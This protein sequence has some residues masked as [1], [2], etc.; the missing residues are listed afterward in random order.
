MA[1]YGVITHMDSMTVSA[2]D[3]VILSHFIR[4]GHNI[5]TV[6]NS[7]RIRTQIRYPAAADPPPCASPRVA[8]HPDDLLLADRPY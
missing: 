1:L 2:I 5:Q 3:H 8:Q 6:V 7:L 4:R